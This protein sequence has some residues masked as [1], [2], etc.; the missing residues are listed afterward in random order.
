MKNYLRA[1]S[2]NVAISFAL[3]GVVL[4]AGV[5]AAIDINEMENSKVTLN[6]AADA[7]V[8]AAVKEADFRFTN[9][10][11]NWAVTGR[12]MGE[13]V[14]AKNLPPNMQDAKIAIKVA[15]NG[16]QFSGDATYD[17]NYQPKLMG[18]FGI[19]NMDITRDVS[20]SDKIQSYLDVHLLIDVSPSMGVG[21][22]DAD[23]TTLFNATGCAL[24]CHYTYNNGVSSN[25]TAARASGA[26]LRIDVV[27]QATQQLIKDM[28]A[29]AT[30]T[31]Q[32][33]VSIDLYSNS[34]IPLL[35]PTTD[36]AAAATAAGQIDLTS[37]LGESGTET[38]AS[39][40][41]LAAKIG[42]SGTG[43][44]ASN[45]KSFVVLISDG[46]QNSAISVGPLVNGNPAIAYDSSYV[47]NSPNYTFDSYEIVSTIKGSACAPLKA[48][49]HTVLTG[50]VDYL[51][52]SVAN[53]G[54]DPRFDFISKNLQGVSK[55]QFQVCA[56]SPKLAYT[57]Q[58]PA[59][60]TV[61]Y[62]NIL[63][64]ILPEAEIA[65]TK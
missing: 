16:N 61:M 1:A 24:A 57:A 47:V 34:I 17:W 4:M 27:R 28:Q 26:T 3:G 36:L 7:G 64:A 63:D 59:D 50:H 19:K 65:L 56:S 52:P 2:G 45:R 46:T 25:Y 42:T 49:G 5:G 48:A 30:G 39:L 60:I 8:L 32:V 51:I 6:A 54:G 31:D 14:F 53:G 15:R 55:A 18:M 13:Q 43:Y 38:E 37:A 12:K 29:R 40:A 11:N 10:D 41:Q 44:S 21:A 20:A 62:Q 9:G 23:Q 58:T 35:A 33:R 22:T